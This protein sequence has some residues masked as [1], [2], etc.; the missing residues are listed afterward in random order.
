MKKII[1]KQNNE[2]T[3]LPPVDSLRSL[4][5]KQ[6]QELHEEHLKDV[7]NLS[8]DTRQILNFFSD[9]DRHDLLTGVYDPD[10]DTE[11]SLAHKES[12]LISYH[13]F[14]TKQYRDKLCSGINELQNKPELDGIELLIFNPKVNLEDF[15]KIKH[16]AQVLLLWSR[17]VVDKNRQLITSIQ[18]CA[19]LNKELEELETRLAAYPENMKFPDIE[20]SN[21][22][23]DEADEFKPPKNPVGISRKP[24]NGKAKKVVDTV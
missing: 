23:A 13:N 2:N 14:K 8:D 5:S 4:E 17:S 24:K 12:G 7:S 16:I 20:E 3:G 19:K 1:R 18:T 11:G 10:T 21:E 9:M 6:L 15:D 22:E